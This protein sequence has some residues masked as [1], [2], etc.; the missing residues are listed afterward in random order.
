MAIGFT[1]K[2]ILFKFTEFSIPFAGS[3]MSLVPAKSELKIAQNLIAFLEEQEV[4]YNC[5][6]L[7]DKNIIAELVTELRKRF[8]SD[9]QKIDKT[10]PL[11]KSILAMRI[12][13][14]KYLDDTKNLCASDEK[15]FLYLGFLRGILGIHIAN[16]CAKYEI[17]L[18]SNLASIMPPEIVV[19][20]DN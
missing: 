6:K 13:C 7:E 8:I 2:E 9:L 11:S 3:G 17:G 16:I 5:Y 20:A 4:L 10:S 15:Y 19:G 1:A 18:S 12:A 14:K